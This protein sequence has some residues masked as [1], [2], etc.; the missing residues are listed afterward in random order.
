MNKDYVVGF[1]KACEARGVDPE[2]LVKRAANMAQWTS[3]IAKP[4]AAG[5]LQKL[6][7]Y[8]QRGGKAVDGAGKTYWGN[9][10]GKTYQAAEKGLQ[11]ADANLVNAFSTRN[12]VR[13]SLNL[14]VDN[15]IRRIQNAELANHASRGGTQ[16]LPWLRRDMELAGR[17]NRVERLRRN[18][19]GLAN[20]NANLDAASA[21][22]DAASA[23][24][25]TAVVGRDRARVGTGLV[26]AGLGAAGI[27]AAE[28]DQKP[29]S[30]LERIQK[31]LN[32]G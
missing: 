20:A 27:A 28:P 3:H 13:T 11:N 12:N 24:R 9:L 15:L 4:G 26:G 30:M 2:L 14:R 7:G 1:V 29:P 16:P 8:L 23:G 31:R 32:I 21:A 18:D 10:S 22:R 25:N 17:G 19:P 6:W 5:V